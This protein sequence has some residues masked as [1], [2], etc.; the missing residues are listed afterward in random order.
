MSSD[1]PAN[2]PIIG[3]TRICLEMLLDQKINDKVIVDVG[4]S[5]GWL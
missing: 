3:R 5:F 2:V 1:F 4:S